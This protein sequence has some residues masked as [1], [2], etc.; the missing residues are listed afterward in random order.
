MVS[1]LTGVKLHDHNCGMKCYRREVLG[2][3]RLYGELHRFVPVLAAGRGYRVGEIVINHRARKFGQ[4]KY[5]F[6]RF[7]KGFL[8]LLT[9]KFL[10]GYG[11]RPQHVLG[12]VGLS[13]FVLGALW[14][15]W[16]AFYWIISRLGI[17][18]LEPVQLARK[19]CAAVCDRP[20]AGGGTI[21]VDRLPGGVVHRLPRAGP[22]TVFHFGPHARTSRRAE[23]HRVQMA[24]PPTS[25]RN[26]VGLRFTSAGTRS[27]PA[28]PIRTQESNTMDT[29]PKP[30]PTP[31]CADPFTAS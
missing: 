3:V 13:C 28:T 25:R 1:G 7:V 19:P 23:A 14:A 2:E 18:G 21:H 29:N 11:Q 27:V 5:G 15:T 17:L 10:T 22:E 30:I 24:S 6:T 8:D 12:T 26:V 31:R 9:V 20:A 4:S 16:L